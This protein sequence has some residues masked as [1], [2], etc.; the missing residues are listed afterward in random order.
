[1]NTGYSAIGRVAAIVAIVIATAW[2]LG[3]RAQGR[4][5][6]KRGEALANTWCINCHLISNDQTAPA[7]ADAPPFTT[8]ATDDGYSDE[9][10]RAFL[11]EPHGP[12]EGFNPDEKQ[13][14]DLIAYI[15]TL[16]K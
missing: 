3:V 16:A 14:N 1:M 5:D 13:I 11:R 10:L 4:I 2:V 12:M 9:R 6:P 8:M 7:S 15:R